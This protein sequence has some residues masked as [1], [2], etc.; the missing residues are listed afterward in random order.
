M[1][2]S[3]QP[4]SPYLVSRVLKELSHTLNCPRNSSNL[5]K[6]KGS[7]LVTGF[8][9][10]TFFSPNDHLQIFVEVSTLPTTLFELNIVNEEVNTFKGLTPLLRDWYR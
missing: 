5:W 6:D 9:I 2:S 3:L 7:F 10:L 4:L 8:C 1:I